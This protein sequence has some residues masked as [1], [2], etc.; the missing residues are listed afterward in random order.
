MPDPKASVI[1]ET[2][3][4]G[5]AAFS[6]LQKD[7]G[8]L[9]RRA[10]LIGAA[11]A[12]ALAVVTKRSFENIDAL[13]KT[14]DA[15]TVSTEKLAGL[16]LAA[17]IT[18]VEQEQLNKALL[19]QQKT[20]FDAQQGLSTATD[21]LDILGLEV[22]D[23]L[24]LSADEQFVKIAK[25]IDEVENATI[26]SGVAASIYGARNV[27]VLK[28]LEL[29]E[30]GLRRYAE[31]AERVGIAVNRV[32]AAKIEQANDAVTIAKRAIEGLANV[33][34][35]ELAPIVEGLATSFTDNIPAADEMGNRVSA[36]IDK[37]AFAVGIVGDAFF[38]W[39]LI[40][41]TVEVAALEAADVMVAGFDKVRTTIDVT[42][43]LLAFYLK[44]M[45]RAAEIA[46]RHENS[47]IGVLRDSLQLS[48]DAA[49][50]Q[51]QAFID[52]E[53]PSERIAE[54]LE[55]SRAASEA[56]ARAV[57]EQAA[58]AIA[59]AGSG[60]PETE[61]DRMAR[62]S[63]EREATR[64]KEQLEAN[65]ETV[66][67]FTLTREEVEREAITR[68]LEILAQA[69]ESD[70]LNQERFEELSMQVALKG[71]E[72]LTKIAIDGMTERERFEAMS[73]KQKTQHILGS[74]EAITAGTAAHNKTMFQINKVAAIANA[75]VST[76]EGVTKALA[77]A[78]PPFN[79]ALAAI[80][81]AAGA[82]QIQAIKATTF[83]SGTTPSVA[84]STATYGGQPVQQS[85]VIPER[86]SGRGQVVLNISV[87]GNIVG[88]SGR[89]EFG[90][91]LTGVIREHVTET[92]D[93]V[94]PPSSRNAQSI[95][96]GL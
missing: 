71:Q 66:R 34:A 27:A 65:L 26:R 60:A 48:A 76:A 37:I 9:G 79:I 42:S 55:R 31:E 29:G 80:T 85:P 2:K 18:G 69:R 28:T 70:L 52:A 3:R 95:R 11:A 17:Q 41:K 78:P 61:E 73:S 89:R 72:A 84:G 68:R 23:L 14:A 43:A 46:E 7:L 96:G 57:A 82:A 56:S 87:N 50:E 20:I 81:A 45:E 51:L 24:G 58:A 83:G 13:A 74:L 44:D 30:E 15:I 12:A 35:V 21:A 91:Y 93:I 47:G 54:A 62:E 77:S 75:V 5:G 22:K 53:K 40:F 6:S 67:Q 39:K 90:E 33:I 88:E 59:T 25:A 16:Q 38:G 8:A 1:I 92:D 36:A 10:A 63:A 32:D 94:V 86:D 19:K 64:L 49:R 4:R